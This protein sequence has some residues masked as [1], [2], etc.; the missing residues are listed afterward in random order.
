R[1][2]FKIASLLAR[3]S[4]KKLQRIKLW[5]L[6]REILTY[7]A[8]KDERVLNWVVCKIEQKAPKTRNE[9]RPFLK[10]VSLRLKKI[11]TSILNDI[12][13]FDK[14]EDVAIEDLAE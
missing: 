4:Y 10:A 8:F 14:L 13:L 11:D 12:E 7:K 3:C 2:D 9:A 5:A 1:N 6:W